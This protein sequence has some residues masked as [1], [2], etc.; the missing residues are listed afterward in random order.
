MA[1]FPLQTNWV[2]KKKCTGFAGGIFHGLIVFGCLLLVLS[3]YLSSPIVWLAAL[4]I[5]G[6]H[7]I[8]DTVQEPWDHK[9]M[10][11]FIGYMLDQL[12]HL[13]WSFLVWMAYLLPI[14]SSSVGPSWYGGMVV[15]GFLF[16]LLVVTYGWETTYFLAVNDENTSFKRRNRSM[17]L[18]GILYTALFFL[19]LLFL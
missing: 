16:G 5:F 10:R 2:Y 8:Q 7:F 18:R 13:W 14:Q 1:D 6:G 11:S 12:G 15:P 9:S 17:I 19:V 3:P 4:S